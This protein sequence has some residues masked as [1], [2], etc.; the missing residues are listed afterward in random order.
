MS[1]INGLISKPQQIQEED[2]IKISVRFRPMIGEKNRKDELTKELESLANPQI[3]TWFM[4]RASLRE[5]WFKCL[6]EEFIDAIRKVSTTTSKIYLYDIAKWQSSKSDPTREYTSAEFKRIKDLKQSDIVCLN[7]GEFFKFLK[8]YTLKDKESTNFINYI[9]DIIWKE[10]PFIWDISLKKSKVTP[11]KN[12]TLSQWCGNWPILKNI[13]NQKVDLTYSGLQY[14]EGYFLIQKMIKDLINSKKASDEI[15]L[16][17]LLPNDEI[18]YYLDDDKSF[19]KDVKNM[20]AKQNLV[21]SNMK[22]TITFIPFNWENDLSKRPYLFNS[23][24]P[25]T[26]KNMSDLDILKV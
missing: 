19:E 26:I 9:N 12:T 13:L 22:I 23:E 8:S 7:S 21:S 14:L 17:F 3:I 1:A 25:L 16:V 10:R 5:D 4:G 2:Q 18:N 24:K 15:N 6:S 20:L 11:P